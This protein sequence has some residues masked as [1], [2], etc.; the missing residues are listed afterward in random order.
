MIS[1]IY[2]LEGA[3]KYACCIAN[4]E[5]KKKEKGKG[6]VV[7]KIDKEVEGEKKKREYRLIKLVHKS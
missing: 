5:K 6:E 3:L 2:L 1:S 7:K 4:Q